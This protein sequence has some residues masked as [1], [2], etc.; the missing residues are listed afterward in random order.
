MEKIEP[1]V[2]ATAVPESR[3]RDPGVDAYGDCIDGCAALQSLI[4]PGRGWAH[5][6]AASQRGEATRREGPLRDEQ[7]A[8]GASAAAL[9]A[10]G[11]STA[12]AA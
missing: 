10:T 4:A 1:R 11:R 12:L 5:V 8:V 7:G 6:G 9:S 2:A 3:A